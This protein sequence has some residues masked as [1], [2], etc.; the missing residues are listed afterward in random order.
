[1]EWSVGGLLKPLDPETA[2]RE[3]LA[4]VRAALPGVAVR[5]TF[6]AGF[7]GETDEDFDELLAFVPLNEKAEDPKARKVALWY[8]QAESMAQYLVER[9]GRPRDGACQ[10]FHG[11]SSY[12]R[13]VKSGSSP[14]PSFTSRMRFR[15]LRSPSKSRA[16]DSSCAFESCAP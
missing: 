9:G 6:I 8:A 12:A 13:K 3:A 2:F 11:R 14:L 5:S 16:I 4:R 1:M 7:P 15:A 10:R